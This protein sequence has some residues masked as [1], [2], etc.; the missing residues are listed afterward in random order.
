M[1]FPTNDSATDLNFGITGM[2]HLQNAYNTAQD[3]YLSL[4][5]CL[6][7]PEATLKL[8]GRTFKIIKMLGEGAFLISTL[9]T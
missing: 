5:S 4:A 1:V 8:N 7:K 2:E 3:L 6:C 9:V